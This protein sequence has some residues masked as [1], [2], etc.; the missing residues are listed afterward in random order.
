V[1]PG[2][3]LLLTPKYFIVENRQRIP[4]LKKV[5]SAIYLR[6]DLDLDR[7]SEEATWKKI[8]LISLLGWSQD[9]K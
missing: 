8:L 6:L 5:A 3:K 1:L 7:S 9:D 2:S 4:N